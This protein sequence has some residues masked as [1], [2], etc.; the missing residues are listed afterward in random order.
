MRLL[1]LSDLHLEFAP[2]QPVR[3]LE[4]D[5]VVLAGDIACPGRQVPH[6]ACSEKVFGNWP[7]LFVP[8]NHEYYGTVL[9][10]ERAA[11]REAA[12]AAG[13]HLLDPGVLVLGGVRFVGATLWTDFALRMPGPRNPG[14][15]ETWRPSVSRSMAEASRWL[16]DFRHI[17]TGGGEDKVFRPIQALELHQAQRAYL[18]K[19]LNEPFD[20]PTVV[21]THHGPHRGSLAP[22]YEA[23]WL[24]GSFVSELPAAFFEVPRLWIHGHTHTTFDYRVGNCRVLSNPR[25]YPLWDGS[26]ENPKFDPRLVVEV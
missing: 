7:V 3:G 16:N 12:D 22:Q 2:F 9:D 21:I 13:I 5:V 26:F 10:D 17:R 4:S 1:I 19:V 25:G 15:P 24:S 6:W 11:T 14:P 23:D 8:G 18:L 20:G